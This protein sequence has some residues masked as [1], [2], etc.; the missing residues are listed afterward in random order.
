MKI[1]IRL[2]CAFTVAAFFISSCKK[3]NGTPETTQ[4]PPTNPPSVSDTAGTFKNE[5]DFDIGFAVD[6]SS[7][8]NW[9]LIL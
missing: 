3:I 5:A 4:P 7:F 6:Y 2:I 8:I 1:K 9:T